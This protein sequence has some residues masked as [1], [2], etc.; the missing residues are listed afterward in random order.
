MRLSQYG[1]LN[2]KSDTYERVRKLDENGKTCRDT[3]EKE[4]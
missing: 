1:A 2:N 4:F 3:L